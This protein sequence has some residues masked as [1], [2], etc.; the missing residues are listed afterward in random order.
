MMVPNIWTVS[1]IAEQKY[2]VD[3]LRRQVLIN[4]SIGILYLI[5]NFLSSS[6]WTPEIFTS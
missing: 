5:Y 4:Q 2:T 1:K 6:L 3:G